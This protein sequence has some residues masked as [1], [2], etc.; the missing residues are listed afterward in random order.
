MIHGVWVATR[1]P[2]AAV[3]GAFELHALETNATI[4]STTIHFKLV[5]FTISPANF[6]LPISDSHCENSAMNLQL[7][8]S[9]LQLVRSAEFEFLNGF[10]ER[11]FVF[12]IQL[13]FNYNLFTDLRIAGIH[14]SIKSSFKGADLF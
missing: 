2:A 1:V 13:A 8:I 5:I 14:E 6:R 3:A 10:F 7:A 11:G 9:H 12:G 4:P